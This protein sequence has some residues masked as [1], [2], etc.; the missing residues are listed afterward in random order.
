MTYW[1]SRLSAALALLSAAALCASLCACTSTASLEQGYTRTGQSLASQIPSWAGGEPQGTP[2][3][4]AAA[5]YPNVFEQAAPRSSAPKLSEDEQK[6]AAA[7]LNLLH[8]RVD[9]RVK[10]AQA[11]DEENTA[12]AIT[13]MTKGQVGQ[14]N[15]G[16]TDTG[17]LR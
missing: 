6:K 7:D 14:L 13:E 8:S 2:N 17:R 12:R 4:A 9:A 16:Q 5:T 3:K 11:H 10:S 1:R 15:A